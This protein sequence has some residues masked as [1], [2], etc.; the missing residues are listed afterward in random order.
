MAV[1]VLLLYFY[2]VT[3]IEKKRNVAQRPQKY[4]ILA[5][6]SKKFLWGGGTAPSPDP[7]PCGEGDTPSSH[8]I[9]LGAF[10]AST[11]LAPLALDLTPQLQLLDP[12]MRTCM[13]MFSLEDLGLGT[14]PPGPPPLATPLDLDATVTNT[15]P[16]QVSRI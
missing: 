11:R 15:Q 14:L 6:R 1:F 16:C 4:V 13:L 2:T 8:L 3:V 12:P 10:G 5:L 7:Y 9:P